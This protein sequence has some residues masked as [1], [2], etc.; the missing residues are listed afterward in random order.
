MFAH[1]SGGEILKGAGLESQAH[2]E[3]SDPTTL[4]KAP[5]TPRPTPITISTPWS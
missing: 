3:L 4:P 1:L 2:L 5:P